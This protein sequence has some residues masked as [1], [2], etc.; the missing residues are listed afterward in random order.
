MVPCI[1]H[2][3]TSAL[4]LIVQIVLG[5]EIIESVGVGIFLALDM[6]F[7]TLSKKC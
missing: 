2:A 5:N 7:M 3:N 6:N 1:L 4:V